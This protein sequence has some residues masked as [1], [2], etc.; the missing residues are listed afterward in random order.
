MQLSDLDLF[1]SVFFLNL[2]PVFYCF[3]DSGFFLFFRYGKA[4]VSVHINAVTAVV[5][6]LLVLSRL[7][8]F[9]SL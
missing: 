3:L 4:S 8:I 2:I 9:L 1:L 5:L 6:N 7:E